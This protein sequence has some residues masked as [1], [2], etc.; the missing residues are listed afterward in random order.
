M[1]AA[2]G[3]A[4]ATLLLPEAAW[5]HGVIAGGEGFY[6]GMLHPLAVPAHLLMLLGLGLLI[7][8]SAWSSD[9]A[10]IAFAA[11]LLVGLFVAGTHL[12]PPPPPPALL[13]VAALAGLLVAV[14]VSPP[15]AGGIALALATGAA[16]GLGSAPDVPLGRGWASTLAGTWLGAGLTLILIASA[17][18]NPRQA[19]HRIGVRVLGSWTAAS[20]LLVLALVMRR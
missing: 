9:G 5:A 15:Q 2:A 18:R 12:A 17:A 19:W 4:L 20:A 13:T 1:R 10:L 14:S 11:A 3:L 8:Q 6:A 16:I 7:G